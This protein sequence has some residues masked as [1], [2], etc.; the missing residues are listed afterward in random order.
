M[1]AVE[2]QEYGGPEVLK[3]VEAEVPEPGPGQV[4]VE[5][6]YTGIN[7]ADLKARA[8]GYR[9]PQL[10][11]VP[12][13]E[14]SGRIRAVGE[15]VTGLSV[16]QEVT[17]MTEGGAYADVVLANAVDGLPGPGGRR[18][19]YGGDLAGRTADG[20][21][22]GARRG[23]AAARGDGARAGRGGR[24]RHGGGAVGEGGGR[25]QRCTGWCRARPRPPTRA[26]TGTTRCSSGSSRT[27]CG[28]RRTAAGSTSPSTR[29]AARP[30]GRAWPRS[31]S[32]GAWSP[33]A[34]RVRRRRGAWGS[35]SC[36]RRGSR[37]ADSRS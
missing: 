35:P 25:R 5:V 18:S 22:P 4:S 1:R 15:G 31:R 17:A 12:G 21:R 2:I 33:S 28:R 27:R 8:E 14:V 24:S 20:V 30:S 32:S 6:A 29:S 10:P 37:S 9:V 26:S 3:V 19:A 34:T 16:G 11:F 23:P 13:L 36:T 7:F